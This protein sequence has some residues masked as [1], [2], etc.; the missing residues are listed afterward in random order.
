MC[1]L[2]IAPWCFIGPLFCDTT[3]HYLKNTTQIVDFL[4]LNCQ[5][6][7]KNQAILRFFTINLYKN[8][9]VRTEPTMTFC[10]KS[11]LAKRQSH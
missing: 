3:N 5:F 11:K 7:N 8:Q 2:T 1:L 6:S 4:Y 10:H 9:E